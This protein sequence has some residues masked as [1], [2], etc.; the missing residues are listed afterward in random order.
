MKYST[1]GIQFVLAIFLPLFGGIYLDKW[2][3]TKVLF[4]LL[5]LVYGFGT[6]LFMTY[7]DLYPDSIKKKSEE[8]E[9]GSKP[10]SSEAEDSTTEDCEP[11]SKP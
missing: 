1:L 2:L 4:T 8:D 7:R 3:G 6:A 11:P 9:E 10:S 5:G